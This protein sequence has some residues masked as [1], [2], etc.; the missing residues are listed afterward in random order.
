MGSVLWCP[1][2]IWGI[3]GTYG[4][5]IEGPDF[6]TVAWTEDDLVHIKP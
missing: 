3:V 5:Q 2:C 1:V 6:G 4:F